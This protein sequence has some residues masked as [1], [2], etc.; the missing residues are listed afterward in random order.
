VPLVFQRW[1]VTG[2]SERVRDTFSCNG[3]RS[4]SD[5]T[6]SCIILSRAATCGL[7]LQP[8]TFVGVTNASATA[9][10]RNTIGGI[11]PAVGADPLV[12]FVNLRLQR[13]PPWTPLL[14]VPPYQWESEIMALVVVLTLG[15]TLCSIF[16]LCS[17]YMT[18][19]NTRFDREWFAEH[20]ELAVSHGNHGKIAVCVENSK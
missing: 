8:S 10:L 12:R 6:A 19:E 3:T 16:S 4:S 18:E 1:D 20:P 13:S 9:C 15:C 5:G 11:Q 7:E 14:A 17:W 2:I